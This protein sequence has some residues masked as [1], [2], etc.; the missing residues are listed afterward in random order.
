VVA[1]A[2]AI[3]VPLTY[4]WLPLAAL[5]VS[6]TLPPAQKVVAPLGVMAGVAGVGFTVIAM[7]RA[8][9]VPQAFV[10]V[11]PRFPGV[12]LL[13]KLTVTELPEPVIVAPVPEYD[14][15][16]VTLASFGTV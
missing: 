3:G 13:E 1:V 9:L 15:L 2:A 6:V 12:A 5:E 11:T 8:A 14:Q 16:Y 10:D 4:H 7:E